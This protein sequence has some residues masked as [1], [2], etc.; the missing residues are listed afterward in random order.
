[1][2]HVSSHDTQCETLEKN[3]AKRAQ[4][5]AVICNSLLTSCDDFKKSAK[6]NTN[7]NRFVRAAVPTHTHVSRCAGGFGH[8]SLILP[9]KLTAI[10]IFGFRNGPN[11]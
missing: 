9:A 4:T 7:M 6:H 3:G 8:G 2:Q 11:H 5:H 10:I 1:M